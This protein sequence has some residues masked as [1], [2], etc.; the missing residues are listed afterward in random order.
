MWKPKVTTKRLERK[1]K[2][3]KKAIKQY[4]KDKLATDSRWALKALI[5]IYKKQ[6][7]DEKK[8]EFT[9][10]N[11][12]VGFTGVDGEILTSFAKQYI[13]KNWLSEKQMV[14]V[15]KKMKKYWK[16][17]LSISDMNKLEMMVAKEGI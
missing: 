1:M 16:Q 7:D 11:N 4:L 5:E 6:T 17:I 3:T 12:E 14:I 8:A 2:V 9:K 10:Y 15:F 13:S